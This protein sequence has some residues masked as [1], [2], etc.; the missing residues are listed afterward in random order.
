MELWSLALE[1]WTCCKLVSGMCA[2][3]L[4]SSEHVN[5]VANSY[6]RDSRVFHNKKS[7]NGPRART[8]KFLATQKIQPENLFRGTKKCRLVT[9]YTGGP[10][11]SEQSLLRSQPVQHMGQRTTKRDHVM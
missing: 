1:L 11:R 5:L 2:H 10:E 4:V 6:R 8:T 9:A 7:L 3:E